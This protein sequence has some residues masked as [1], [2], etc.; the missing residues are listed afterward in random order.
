MRLKM[1]NGSLCLTPLRA[2][3]A[4]MAVLLGVN[5]AE[6]KTHVVS[7]EQPTFIVGATTAGNSSP[8]IRT[9][10]DVYSTEGF[11]DLVLVS[12]YK[13]LLRNPDARSKYKVIAVVP[14]NGSTEVFTLLPIVFMS[15]EAYNTV[16]DI[17]TNRLLRCMPI[18][19]LV[20]CL[21][22][23]AN[24]Y[25][26][27]SVSLG[28]IRSVTPAGEA[29]I[30]VTE[31]GQIVLHEVSGSIEK[32]ALLFTAL[33]PPQALAKEIQLQNIAGAFVA[34][35]SSRI[36]IGLNS[37]CN[38]S[39]CGSKIWSLGLSDGSVTTSK[40]VLL[41]SIRINSE[42]EQG[43]FDL[44]N[45]KSVRVNFAC[46]SAVA[47]AIFDVLSLKRRPIDGPCKM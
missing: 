15:A 28:Q 18:N 12:F 23:V 31:K 36:L 22:E 16:R 45:E 24:L 38:G 7:P 40:R 3:G 21:S 26:V 32:P 2:M 35:D 30:F 1:K 41:P 34:N 10:F 37:K 46:G 19:D 27:V 9:R 42:S 43:W 5:N 17:G 8:S 4:V 14:G 20:L 33:A 13:D 29:L 6:G 39:A 11:S 25:K 47:G 44:Q